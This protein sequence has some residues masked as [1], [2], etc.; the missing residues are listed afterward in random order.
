M[1]PTEHKLLSMLSSND[2]TFFIPPY[3]RNY[4]WTNEQCDIFFQDVLRTAEDNLQGKYTEHFFGFVTYVQTHTAFGQPNK[5]TLVDGQ[6]RIT[7]TM[8]LLLALRDFSDNVDTKSFI[9]KKYLKNENVTDETEYKIKLKQVERDWESYRKLVLGEELSDIEKD[10]AVNRNYMFFLSQLRNLKENRKD[11]PVNA[12]IEEGLSKFSVVTV[13]LQPDRNKWEN[14]QE[15][16]ESMNSLGKPL[17][18][19][20]LVRNYLLLGLS[21]NVQTEL[22]KKYWLHIEEKLG[23]NISNY[24]RDYMQMITGTAFKKATEQNYKELYRQFKENFADTPSEDILSDLFEAADS[25]AY[26]LPDGETNVKIIDRILRDLQIMKV[27]TAYSFMLALFLKWKGSKFSD[28]DMADILD[29][30]R[31]YILRRR[32]V[33]VNQAENK[34]FPQLVN[35]IPDL[36][37]AND[38][39]LKMFK[40]LSNQESNMRLP[41]DFEIKVY[42]D[43]A[44]FYNFQYCKFY[45]ALLEESITKSRPDLNDNHLQIEHIMPQT[46]TDA[47]RNDLGDQAET[48]HQQF[49]NT[50]GNLT[51]I[52]HNQ[53]LGQKSFS[54]KK[55]LYDNKAG[56]QIAKSYITNCK[57][58]NKKS[59]QRRMYWI[60]NY[61]LQNVLPIPDD[62]RKT[63]NF[64]LKEKRAL[65][66]L[67]LQLIGKTVHF[68]KDPSITARVV[69]D[70][71][72]EFE[73]KKWLLSPLTREIMKRKGL[74]SKSGSYQGS[75]YWAYEGDRL[76]D[77]IK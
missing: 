38:K 9:E 60:V 28:E 65:S 11:I 33:K 64:S 17:A 52:R 61:L 25:Y 7:T 77:L 72:V 15:I 49:D 56:L 58:W 63:N 67:E 53:E 32:L 27:T 42:L 24:I 5:L 68:Y 71:H 8:L 21:P 4:E 14:P 19:A 16:F 50:I 29:A 47:W 66:F 23:K 35:D 62:M 44:N 20:D 31:I 34:S 41:N 69:D 39:R 22:Y 18:L 13:E 46:L 43:T 73:G 55:E 10:S 1:I 2:V 3:Q 12:L 37:E 26:L 70:K 59:I 40:I 30:F 76:F 75:V 36:I 48:V 74:C 51:L 6:Q 45:L 57:V 54:E